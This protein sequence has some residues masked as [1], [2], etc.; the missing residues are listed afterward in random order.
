[1]YAPGGRN[2]AENMTWERG[3]IKYLRSSWRF[4]GSIVRAWFAQKTVFS[5]GLKAIEGSLKW[6]DRQC[7]I[8]VNL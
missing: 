5:F 2:R 8:C 6:S 1:M 3:R 7:L 4:R